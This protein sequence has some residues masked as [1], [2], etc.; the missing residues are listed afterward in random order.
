MTTAF[1]EIC[2]IFIK[3]LRFCRDLSVNYIY[4]I[5]DYAFVNLKK[6]QILYVQR[7]CFVMFR[8]CDRLFCWWLCKHFLHFYHLY[9][10]ID[11]T[12]SHF[13]FVQNFLFKSSQK[14]TLLEPV[15]F[16]SLP[17]FFLNDRKNQVNSVLMPF[18][19]INDVRK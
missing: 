18:S 5:P 3:M 16:R 4:E 1:S 10:E 11:T 7:L 17:E 13:L 9:L 12:S 6:L 8:S 2:D 19:V 14:K 15:V